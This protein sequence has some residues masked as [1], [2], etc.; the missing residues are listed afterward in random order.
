LVSNKEQASDKHF[1]PIA[2][3]AASAEPLDHRMLAREF[4]GTSAAMTLEAYC[5]VA[6][7][8]SAT[9]RALTSL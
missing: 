1:R 9:R 6:N 2:A 7:T 4:A 3:L 5:A 8:G